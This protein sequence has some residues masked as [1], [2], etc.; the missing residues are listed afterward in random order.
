MASL[1]VFATSS[2]DCPGLPSSYWEPLWYAAHTHAN[3]EKHV[4]EQLAQKSVE[5]FLPLYQTVRRWKDRMVQLQRPLF[6]G[7][8][9]VRLAL[10]DRLHVLRVPGVAKLVGFNGTPSALP[11]GEIDSLRTSLATGVHAE[12]HPYLTV[13]CR[14]RVKSGPLLGMEGILVRKK[15]RERFV[16]SLDLIVRSVAVDVDGVDLDCVSPG[17]HPSKATRKGAS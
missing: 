17:R 14:M 4:A 15:N 10:H 13:G 11:Q 9:F 7:Y 6:P 16:L 2:S 1:S 12:P 3:H 5:H 8:I